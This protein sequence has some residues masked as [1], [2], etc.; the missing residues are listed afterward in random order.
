VHHQSLNQPLTVARPVNSMAGCRGGTADRKV[1]GAVG[2]IVG[3]GSYCDK[4]GTKPNIY[5]ITLSGVALVAV[6]R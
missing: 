2:A 1:L 3:V 4:L 5:T 6:M